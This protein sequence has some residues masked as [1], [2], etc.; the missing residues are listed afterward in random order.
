MGYF[1]WLAA[2]EK[3][4]PLS[5]AGMTLLTMICLGGALGLLADLIFKALRIDLGKYKKEYEEEDKVIKVQ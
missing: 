5:Y 1:E 3:A 4:S 2:I